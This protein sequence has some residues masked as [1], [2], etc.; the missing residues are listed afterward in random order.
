MAGQ[1]VLNVA[2]TV[3]FSSGQSVVINLGGTDPNGVENQETC[4]IA[5]VQAGISLTMVNKLSFSP[6][7]TELVQLCWKEM[8]I[9]AY[10]TR[11]SAV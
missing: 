1:T 10:G 5:S 4:Q 11:R 9:N 3:D 6:Y 7:T 2:S 8:T